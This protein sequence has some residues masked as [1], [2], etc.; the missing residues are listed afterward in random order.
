MV[1]LVSKRSAVDP[2]DIPVTKRPHHAC[3]S[4]SKPAKGVSNPGAVVLEVSSAVRLQSAF[5]GF[6]V[7]SSG[8]AAQ[9]RTRSERLSQAMSA[10]ASAAVAKRLR[11]VE[12]CRLRRAC[13]QLDALRLEQRRQPPQRVRRP[14]RQSRIINTRG[15]MIN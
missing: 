1:A 9:V 2:Q 10:Q 3:K 12:F 8:L 7:R 6:R 11:S 15:P 4:A 13:P 5:R 14:V